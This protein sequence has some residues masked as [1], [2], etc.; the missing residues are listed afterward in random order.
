MRIYF[1]C[2]TCEHYNSMERGMKTHIERQ[3]EY[4][5]LTDA[6]EHIVDHSSYDDSNHQVE[7]R[8]EKDD[9]K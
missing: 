6:Y 5:S 9:D 3:T 7:A 2:T 1:Y 8:I 4:H